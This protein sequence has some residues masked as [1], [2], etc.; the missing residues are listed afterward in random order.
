MIISTIGSL[1]IRT[2]I[3]LGFGLVLSVLAVISALTLV[4]LSGVQS[5]VTEVVKERQPTVILSKELA[6]RLQQ[7][8]SSMGFYLLS[9]EENHKSAYQNGLSQANEAL[10]AQRMI[11]NLDT[12]EDGALSVDEMGIPEEAF[13]KLDANE[14]GLLDQSEL[15]SGPGGVG[16]IVGAE[17]DNQL[18]ETMGEM[19]ATEN[20]Q[21]LNNAVMNSYLRVHSMTQN[22]ENNSNLSLFQRL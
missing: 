9:K 19:P 16:T 18:L 1:T 14:D 6:T 3:W 5:G 12:D 11:Q 15:E 20:L 2:K 13:V 8:A 7:A 22:S 17:T 21:S 4:N 10:K